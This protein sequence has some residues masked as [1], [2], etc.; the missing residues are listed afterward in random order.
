MWADAPW[1]VSSTMELQVFYGGRIPRKLHPVTINNS[2]LSRFAC[3]GRAP[4]PLPL[5]CEA[6]PQPLNPRNPLFVYSQ[7]PRVS[8]RT[9][10]SF[11]GI[12]H[13]HGGCHC[14]IIYT[15]FLFFFFENGRR[16]LFRY[17]FIHS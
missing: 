11:K 17:F 10:E 14:Y 7:T 4:P 16:L 1:F 15:F 6:D 13:V 5:V 12:F 8:F 2:E 9:L 3:M